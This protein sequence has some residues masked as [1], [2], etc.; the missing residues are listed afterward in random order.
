MLEFENNEVTRPKDRVIISKDGRVITPKLKEKTEAAGQSWSSLSLSKNL[1]R[2]LGSYK[3][4]IPHINDE[5]LVGL[6]PRDEWLEEAGTDCKPAIFYCTWYGAGDKV[7]LEFVKK[8]LKAIKE[9]QLGIDNFIIDAGW[10]TRPGDWLSVD[11]K[12]FPHGLKEAVKLLEK[13]GIEA[14]IWWGLYNVDKKSELA[15]KHPD[16]LVRNE[17]TKKPISFGYFTAGIIPP[18]YFLDPRIPAVQDYFKE[19]RAK[20][21]EWGFKGVKLDFLTD[22]F[23]IPGIDKQAA[24]DIIHQDLKNFKNDGF[25]VLACGCPFSAAVGA[26]DYLRISNDSGL[27]EKI[28]PSFLLK[29]LTNPKTKNKPILKE[30]NRQFVSGVVRGVERAEIAKQVGVIGDPD[31]LCFNDLYLGDIRRLIRGEEKT[32]DKLGCFTIGDDLSLLNLKQIES[33]KKLEG[34]FHQEQ[35]IQAR[36]AKFL[37][38]LINQ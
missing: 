30:I 3:Y 17:K 16:W 14:W 11:K 5:K 35:A 32:I 19:I 10:A 2:I 36:I 37:Q 27:P 31:M 28:I 26:A 22:V 15:K 38:S 29:L 4:R 18:H 12:K 24:N 34:Q 23:L 21:K 8:Q 7:N 20:L 9:H 6:V 25:K 13:A 33:L 1:S